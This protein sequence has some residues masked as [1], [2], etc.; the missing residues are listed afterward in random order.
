MNQNTA[1]GKMDNNLE[2]D[3]SAFLENTRGFFWQL[4]GKEKK[5]Y[6]ILSEIESETQFGIQIRAGVSGGSLRDFRDL[7]SEL[8]DQ[9]MVA[10]RE[11]IKSI[12]AEAVDLIE[13][14]SSS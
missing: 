3:S 12:G 9:R 11:L 7:I 6:K 1:Y 10:K 5:L 8:N 14:I 13:R 4:T 2:M